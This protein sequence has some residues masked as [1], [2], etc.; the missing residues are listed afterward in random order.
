MGRFGVGQAIVRLEDERLLTGGGRYTDDVSPAG[1]AAAVFV[2]SPHAHAEIRAVRT[3][4]ARAMPGV[5]AVLTVDDLDQAG[6]GN[7]PCR[8]A[9]RNKDGRPVLVPPRPPLAR[10]HVRHVG[11]P[12]ACVV[13]AT[14]AEAREAAEAVEVDYAALA[15]VSDP[16]RALE[17]GAPQLW[18]DAPGNLALDWEA[19][20]REAVDRL[21]AGAVRVTVVDL[22]NN[23]VVPNAM[24]PRGCLGEFDQASGRYTLR[25]GGQGVHSMQGVLAEMM[26]LEPALIR[27][28]QADVGGGFGM[29]IW[30]YPEYPVCL[31][32]ARLTGR[33][34][35]WVSDRSEGFVSDT[36]GRDHVTRVQIAL[37]ADGRMLALRA[38]ITANLG[39]YLSQFGPFIPTDAGAKMYNGVYALQAVHVECRGAYTNTVPVDAYRGAGRPEAAYAVERAVDAAAR[40]L[41]MDPAEFRRRNF[42]RPEQMPFRTAMATTYDSGEFERLMDAA[43]SQADAAGFPQR[44]AAA[45]AKGKL[46]GL[47]IAY[48]IEQCSGGPDENARIE[49]LPEG[50]VRLYIGTQSNGQGHATA[51]AQLISDVFGI[52]PGLVK[53]VQGDTDLVATGRGTGGSRS[54]PVGGVAV[55]RAGEAAAEAGRRLAGEMLEA[56]EADIELVDGRYRVLGTDRDVGLFE[57]AASAGGRGLEGAGNFQPSIHTFPNGCH[58]CELEI[59]AATG[60]PEIVRYT[61][62]DD[63]GVVLNPLMLA[64]QVHG[65]VAQGIGQALLEEAVYDATGQLLSGTFLDYAMPRAI[66]IPDIAFSTVEVRCRTNPLGMKGA[67]EAGAIGA[68]PAVINA[69]VDALADLGVRHVDMPATPERLWRLVT[70]RSAA[71]AA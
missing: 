33:P 21:L 27:V 7:L 71:K 2:R 57:V 3:D 60:V 51:Y 38:S 20:E 59:D 15:A 64:G 4:A 53:T 68:P 28:I 39:A 41:G 30:V 25:T 10:G 11:D 6:I 31:L 63:F 46:R 66:G 9:V 54:V 26:G 8:A 16:V 23:R 61:I 52:E 37:D 24:E 32:A 35:K 22:V 19:G 48:Y 62:V 47:G 58:V 42:I 50:R 18:P 45:R 49:V 65:G 29:K 36:H 1:Q 44:R 34:V 43:L 12:V 70:E 56:A 13:A 69:V 55:Q 67:G 17:P 14:L 5:L 40:D